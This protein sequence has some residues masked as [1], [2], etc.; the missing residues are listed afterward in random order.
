MMLKR[1]SKVITGVKVTHAIF[2]EPSVYQK[3]TRRERRWE[4]S[5]GKAH[6]YKDIML[7]PKVFT[8]ESLKH[9]LSCY[10]YTLPTAKPK[11][12]LLPLEGEVS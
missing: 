7:N 9:S 3:G 6:I 12:L 11:R 8:R 4:V 10:N 5:K 1:A 2:L